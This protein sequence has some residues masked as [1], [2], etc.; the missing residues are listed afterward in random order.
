MRIKALLLAALVA[1]ATLAVVPATEPQEQSEPR[2]ADLVERSERRLIQID[3]SVR[4][5]GKR[6]DAERAEILATDFELLIEGSVHPIVH[7]DRIC[8]SSEQ[9]DAA[10]VEAEPTSTADA[11]E[12]GTTAAGEQAAITAEA[13]GAVYVF[14]IEHR[15]LTM[16]GQQN[17]FEMTK[18]LIKE[19]VGGRDR[20]LVVSSGR[21]LIQSEISADPDV[22]LDAVAEASKDVGQWSSTTYAEEEVARYEEINRQ[23]S[24]GTRISVA[25]TY[26]RDERQSV[27]NSMSRVGAVL[28]GLSDVD[29]P[30]IVFYFSDTMR[31]NAGD[32][33]LQFIGESP[34]PNPAQLAF[35]RLV[36]TAGAFG[37]RIYPVQA[38]GLTS[39][40]MR[41]S[42]AVRRADLATVRH[43]HADDT[44][45]GLAGE[46]GG[47]RFR[48]G[49]DSASIRGVVDRIRSDLDCFWLLSVDPAELPE[50]RSLPLRVRFVPESPRTPALDASYDIFARGQITIASASRREEGVLL[51]AHLGHGASDAINARV[52]MV[53]LGYTDG[54][55]DVLVQ[56]IVPASEFLERYAGPLEWELGLSRTYRDKVATQSAMRVETTGGAPPAVFESVWRFQPGTHEIV[57]VARETRFEQLASA[58]LEV[59]WPDP[60]RV[61]LTIGPIVVV[62]SSEALFVTRS[63]RSSGSSRGQR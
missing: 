42:S 33:Y 21:R 1:L 23:P 60:K 35:D 7:A 32:H 49:A 46:T 20:G 8:R 53:P 15:H 6:K 51:A 37:V 59:E 17:T 28:G 27:M 63:W 10:P 43:R 34:S 62:Q 38:Q 24:V 54:A 18:T 9:R 2:E 56:F 16:G 36:E 52:A 19:L 48:G 14:F 29:P 55:F 41:E 45:V 12:T 11:A 39:L 47:A 25:H 58:H 50:D 26:A 31:K 22:L 61:P 13:P 4:P 44:L 57:G 3:V 5:K 30:K 40:G